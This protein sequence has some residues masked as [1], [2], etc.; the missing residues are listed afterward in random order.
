[1]QQLS[2]TTAGKLAVI[3]YAGNTAPDHT[4][5]LHALGAH[6]TRWRVLRR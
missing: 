1:M 2:E 3:G 6:L 5:H 4:D